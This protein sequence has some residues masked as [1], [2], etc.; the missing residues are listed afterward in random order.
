ML[1]NP[2]MAKLQFKSDKQVKSH[3]AASGPESAHS[4]AH[5]RKESPAFEKAEHRLGGKAYGK[6][7]GMGG[8]R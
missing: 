5:E 7:K 4:M 2:D 3:I 1:Y 6:R 8:K